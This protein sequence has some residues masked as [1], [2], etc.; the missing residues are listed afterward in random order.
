MSD[1]NQGP[2][3]LDNLSPGVVM[4]ASILPTPAVG[5]EAVRN[6]I[7]TGGSMYVTQTF[8]FKGEIAGRDVLEFDAE[9]RT[10]EAIHCIVSIAKNDEGVITNITLGHSPLG[11]V[12]AL[13]ELVKAAT[14]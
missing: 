14:T 3:W 9:L 6:V 13:A 5:P 8:T 4:T 11:A 7:R 2:A 12:L 10:G 1:T